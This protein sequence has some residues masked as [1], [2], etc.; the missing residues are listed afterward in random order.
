MEIET[1]F[2]AAIQSSFL[3]GLLHGVNPCG[4]SWL[5]SA[6]FVTVERNGSRVALLTIAFISGTA[7]ACVALGAALGAISQFIAV[8]IGS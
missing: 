3:L 1:L 2:F 5:V 4:H 7:L 8:S 6:P